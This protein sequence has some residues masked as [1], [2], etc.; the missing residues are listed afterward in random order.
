MLAYALMNKGLEMSGDHSLAGPFYL[1]PDCGL[2]QAP[3]ARGGVHL[4]PAQKQCQD[5]REMG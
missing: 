2:G 5:S 1:F 3:R 4:S